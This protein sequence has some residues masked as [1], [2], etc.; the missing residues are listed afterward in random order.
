M[1]LTCPRMLAFDDY[2]QQLRHELVTAYGNLRISVEVLRI[3]RDPKAILGWLLSIDRA[4]DRC[5]ALAAQLEDVV[6]LGSGEG[7][8]DVSRAAE[9]S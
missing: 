6:V 1:G 4:A 9:H 7:G 3:E 2:Q 8:G 5:A